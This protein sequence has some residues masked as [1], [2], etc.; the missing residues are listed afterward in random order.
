[1]GHRRTFERPFPTRSY[2]RLFVLATEGAET[3]P[4][5]FALFNSKTT[6][7]VYRLVERL[8]QC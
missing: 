6:T 4:Q 2:R 8:Q 5:Y 3:E 1:M 7:V